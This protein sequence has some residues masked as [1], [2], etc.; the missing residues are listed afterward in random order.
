LLLVGACERITPWIA[1]KERPMT[2]LLTA[3][4][5]RRTVAD[6][7]E[8]LGDIPPHRVLLQPLPGTATEQDV[9]A[10]DA[11]EDRLCELVEG[12]LVEKAM[13]IRESILAAAL[14]EFLRAFV[15]PRNLGLVS[16]EAGLVRLMPGLIRI[17]DVGFF[18]W[19]RLPNRRVP[20]EVI[21]PVAPNLAVE[22]LSESNTRA[23]MTR[24][25]REYFAAGVQLVWQVDPDARTVEVFTTADQFVVRTEA[26]MLDGAE[27]LPGFSLPLRTLFAEL[28]RQG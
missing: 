19:D 15:V 6:L 26:D 18:S 25:R 12:V 3:P 22:V 17:P 2:T 8:Q 16:G 4:P 27:V 14:I 9:L 10:M 5:V 23:E 28:D 7:L 24:K 21:A 20:R 11:H 1:R 13:S